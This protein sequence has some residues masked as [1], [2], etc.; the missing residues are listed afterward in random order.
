MESL[1]FLLNRFC[2]SL[3]NF[4]KY[5]SNFYL[6]KNKKNKGTLIS[7]NNGVLKAK[8]EYIILPDPDDMLSKYILNNCYKLAKKYNL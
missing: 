3:K 8:G 1:Y 6:L 7:R 2:K 4:L 5:S